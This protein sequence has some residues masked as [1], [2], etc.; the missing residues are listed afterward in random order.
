MPSSKFVRTRMSG[1]CGAEFFHPNQISP[2]DLVR[3]ETHFPSDELVAWLGFPPFTR[4]RRCQW[5]VLRDAA[6]TAQRNEYGLLQFEDARKSVW[7]FGR[8][9]LLHG[10]ADAPAAM[11]FEECDRE[12]GPLR[13]IGRDGVCPVAAHN[14][15]AL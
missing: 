14:G 1:T 4:T 2:G 13:V 12:R 15:A 10:T 11:S 3:V 9:G 6:Q 8:D 5:C 7:V